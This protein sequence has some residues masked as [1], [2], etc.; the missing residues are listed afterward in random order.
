M[1]RHDIYDENGTPWPTGGEIDIIE[2]STN[3]WGVIKVYGTVHC[4][5]GHSGNHIYCKG[6]L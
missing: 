6:L 3:I 4:D 2:T 1:F 5:D